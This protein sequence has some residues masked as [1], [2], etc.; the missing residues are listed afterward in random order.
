MTTSIIEQLYEKCREPSRFLVPLLFLLNIILVFPVFF[1]N[2]R[3]IG[4][5]DE[6]IYI[7]SGRL[8]VEKGLLPEPAW[9]PLGTLLYAITYI[10]VQ[11]TAF[12]LVNSCTIGRFILFGLLWISTY[13]VAKQLSS[14]FNSLIMSGLL[15][16]SPVLI[17]ILR[18]PSDALFA[19]MSAFALWQALSCYNEKS[20]TCV[21]CVALRGLVCIDK[22]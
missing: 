21:A 6:S 18:N 12:W 1:P 11:K 20:K 2:L 17:Y 9:N 8:L 15:L 7:N 16:S 14:F 19:A 10:P 22:E 5:W 13:L 4:P 3:E